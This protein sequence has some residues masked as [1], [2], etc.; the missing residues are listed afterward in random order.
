MRDGCQIY[1]HRLKIMWI[2][3]A[4]EVYRKEGRIVWGK[5]DLYFAPISKTIDRT[6][7]GKRVPAA[8]NRGRDISNAGT[9]MI[10]TMTHDNVPKGSELG[11]L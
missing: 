11:R 6:R 9:C 5:K 7:T 4:V 1:I 10:G 3:R 2:V 8:G